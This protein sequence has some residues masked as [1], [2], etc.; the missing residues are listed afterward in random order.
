MAPR[1]WAS[2]AGSQPKNR[3]HPPL[4]ERPLRFPLPGSLDAVQFSVGTKL[5][6]IYPLKKVAGPV[7]VDMMNDGL[8]GI[9]LH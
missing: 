5:L 4:E 3:Q 8:Q 6:R 7:E 1:G 2:C 9:A